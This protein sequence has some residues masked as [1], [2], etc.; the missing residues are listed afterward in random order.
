MNTI[1]QPT[2]KP[3]PTLPL[4]LC[5]HCEIELPREDL[6]R[7]PLCGSKDVEKRERKVTDNEDY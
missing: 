3:K 4:Y 2:R 1:P 5:T 7:C 6:K